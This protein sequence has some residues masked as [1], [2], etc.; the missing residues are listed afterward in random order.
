[1][2]SH[3]LPIVVLSAHTPRGSAQAAAALG[4]GALEAQPKHEL[5]LDEAGSPT[6]VAFRRRLKRLSRARVAATRSAAARGA[7]VHLG[8]AAAHGRRASI[9]GIC[10]STGGPPVL[11]DVLA[12]LPLG[13]P[14]PVLVVQ[15]ITRGFAEPL[16]RWLD[17]CIQLPV[18]M[19]ADAAWARPGVWIAPDDAHLALGP[20]FRLRLDRRPLGHG[21]RPSGDVLLR[22]AA[23]SVGS[24]AAAVILTGMGRDGAQGLAAV[25][26]AGGVTIAQDE[27]TSAVYGMPRAAAECGAELILSSGEIGHALVQLAVREQAG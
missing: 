24:R 13:F 16:A 10:A 11:R 17:E 25:R 5:R 4:A 2:D 23:D 1:M 19:A 7:A 27:A 21:H 20:D 8:R 26:R 12:Q 15:H 14:A 9:I 3:P 6:A 18:G 22:S